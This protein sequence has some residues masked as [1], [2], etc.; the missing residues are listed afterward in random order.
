VLAAI[1]FK[2]I[3]PFRPNLGA[4]SGVLAGIYMFFEASMSSPQVWFASWR[5]AT[6]SI[7]LSVTH[8]LTQSLFHRQSKAFLPVFTPLL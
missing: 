5:V 6:L 8:N 4:G 3:W 1:I 7:T 2:K